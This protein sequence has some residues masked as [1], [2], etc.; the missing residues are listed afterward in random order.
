MNKKKNRKNYLSSFIF[1]LFGEKWKE[2]YLEYQQVNVD[3]CW[4]PHIFKKVTLVNPNECKVGIWDMYI[5][6]KG[7]GHFQWEELLVSWF[8]EAIKRSE[9]E[10]TAEADISMLFNNDLLAWDMETFRTE[11]VYDHL[12]AS[13]T[14]EV[15]EESE[16]E[17]KL[18]FRIRKN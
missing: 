9:E 6:W 12:M 15:V 10:G 16:M 18:A 13:G 3:C 8:F 5:Y 11:E 1:S 14:F 17:L 4:S 2:E 7:T